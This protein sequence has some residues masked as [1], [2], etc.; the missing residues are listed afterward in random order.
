MIVLLCV[1]LT[2]SCANDG[3][4]E[5][6]QAPDCTG[7]SQQHIEQTN[8]AMG[9]VQTSP[10]NGV[11]RHGWL[12]VESG[13]LID[14]HGDPVQLRGV[15][16]HGIMWFPQYGNYR[17]IQTLRSRGANLFRIAMYTTEERGYDKNPAQ[18]RDTLC[19]ILENALGSDLY[20][21][22]DWHVLRDENPNKYANEAMAFFDEVSA[23]YADEP[24]V[25]YE[26]CNEPNGD[27]TWEDVYQYAE[28]VIPVIRK[29]SPDALILVGTPGYCVEIEEAADNPLP[30]DN[31]MYTFHYYADISHDDYFQRIDSVLNRGFG[32]FVSEWGMGSEYDE[33]SFEKLR[34]KS[35]VFLDYL[36]DRGISWASW[37]LS[38]KDEGHA[39]LRSDSKS[40]SNWEDN[41]LT[42]YGLYVFQRLEG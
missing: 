36:D 9:D 41:E 38:N 2:A 22:V 25:I 19:S 31:I 10:D 5:N 28:K 16:S 40:L 7:G 1:L 21:I 17:A 39:L 30:Y 33:T 29:N 15:S 26:I 18:A 35:A 3:T 23:L 14:Q 42:A 13:R 34:S 32:V 8:V 20:A 24:G 27:T 11:G 4:L 12:S 6:Q 37:A